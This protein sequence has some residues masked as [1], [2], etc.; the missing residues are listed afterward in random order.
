MEKLERF[1]WSEFVKTN[2]VVIVVWM[3]L[4]PLLAIP[5]YTIIQA[6]FQTSFLLFYSWAGHWVAHKISQT[7]PLSYINP[8]IFV[9]HTNT[10]HVPR[11]VNLVIETV[12][13][14]SCFLLLLP[15]TDLFG[16]HYLSP[17]LLLGAM[18][19]YIFIHIFDYSLFGDDE[20]KLHHSMHMCN[21][22]PDFLDIAF[23]TRCNNALPMKDRT[24]ESI[25]G[26][27]AFGLAFLI[28]RKF[29]LA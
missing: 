17:S 18:F 2:G 13:D 27:A 1:N 8:H 19:L 25:H 22:A 23:N 26:I 28:K 5:E 24:V 12:L 4:L 21:Y 20:H 16:R 11:W 29:N 10:Y 9:H 14:A 7:G 3:S 6:L 15:F